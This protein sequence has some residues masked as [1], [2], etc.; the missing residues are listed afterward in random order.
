MVGVQRRGWQ[1]AAIGAG[2]I[3][4]AAAGF[5][6]VGQWWGGLAGAAVIA[7][8]SFVVSEA[9]DWWKG[10]REQADHQ[11]QADRA[12]RDLLDR[13][14]SPVAEQ[15]A[16]RVHGSAAGWLRA[17]QRVV[18][19][20]DRPELA[21]LR[22]WCADDGAPSVMLVTG[23]G[24]VGKT[25]LALRLAEEQQDIGWLCRMVRLGGEAEVVGA[26]RAVSGGSVLLVVDYAETRPDLVGLLRA[27]AGD[28][29][30]RLRVVLL[31]RGAGEWWV[32]LEAS[33]DAEVRRLAAAPGPI[34]GG[35]VTG[36][37]ASGIELVRAAVPQFSRAVGVVVAGPVE[38]VIQSGP[39]P[40][41]VLHAA[42][43]LAVLEARD[44]PHDGPVRVVADKQVLAGLLAREKAFWLGSAAGA[45]LTGPGGVDSVVAGQAVAVA[46]L[47]TVADESAAVAALRRV[48]D[49]SD[50]PSGQL[51]QI[52]R[53][54][55]QLY[56]AERLGATTAPRWWGYLQPDLL[57]EW[58][59]VSQLT[60]APDFAQACL[61]GLTTEQAHGALTVLARAS[62]HRTEASAMIAA[63]LR[64]GLPGLGVPAVKVAVQ[65]GGG[66]GKFIAGVLRDA[67]AQSEILIEIG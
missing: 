62:A 34:A 46:C 2:V 14:S 22:E 11:A 23:A 39:V 49:L 40:I 18:G 63:A 10:R 45:N 57:A 35:A 53:W 15:P 67:D 24:G 48:P 55:R 43:L 31:A 51:H 19:F 13:V 1:R 16:D 26:A 59:T 54:L 33:A 66:L 52:A 50:A 5:G 25:R 41:L 30:D 7:G 3:V 17:D 9:S 21:A 44:N 37:A 47:L 38:V 32:H 42:A 56:P 12:A 58:H 36:E 6:V 64:V 65:T 60:D 29:G 20:S 8:G 4:A 28:L 27:V 61:A